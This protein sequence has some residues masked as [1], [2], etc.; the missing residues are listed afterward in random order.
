MSRSRLASAL[1]GLGFGLL[2]YLAYRTDQTVS[3]RLMRHLCGPS[4]YEQLRDA[5]RT[6]FPLSAVLRGCLPSALWCF[7]VTSLVGGWRVRLRSGRILSLTWLPPL[8]NA[9]WEIIQ[10]LGWTDGR[11]DWRDCVAGYAGWFLATA[12]FFRTPAPKDEIAALWNW[13]VGVAA[14]G[15]ACMALAD[16]W[17]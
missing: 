13:R 7:I 3:N 9:G 4:C 2:F 8:F 5:L 1:L 15:F 14:A 10:W 16:V 17:K 6:W 11:A 12:L